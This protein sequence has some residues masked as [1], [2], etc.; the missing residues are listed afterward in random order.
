MT[1][2]TAADR[3]LGVALGDVLGIWAHPDDDTYTSAGV[4]LA[5]RAAGH[6]VSVVT[7]T[8]GELGGDGD[9]DALGQVRL[10]ELDAA[11]A[12]LDV[13]PAR[14]L[15]Y[16]DGTCATASIDRAVRQLRAVIEEVRPDTI[17]TFGVDGLTGHPDHRAVGGWAARAWAAAAPDARLLLTATSTTWAA[18][19]ADINARLSVFAPGLPRTTL[20]R[21]LA[22]HLDLDGETLDRKVAA[23]QA[24][25]S[26]TASVIASIGLRAFRDWVREEAFVAARPRPDGHRPPAAV[27]LTP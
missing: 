12:I 21:D 5:V 20:P 6:R 9:P 11:L 8:R 1:P 7:A 13:P 2:A 19:F 15:G 22:L 26:Q 4:M 25:A 18:R 16:R 14:W 3:D 23:L 17:L 27:P 10:G 24:H